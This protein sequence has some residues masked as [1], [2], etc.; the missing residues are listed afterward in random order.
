M[1]YIDEYNLKMKHAQNAIRFTLTFPVH[2][3]HQQT[4]WEEEKNKKKKKPHA[5]LQNNRYYH[6]LDST[7]TV[8]RSTTKMKVEKNM[9]R[10]IEMNGMDW[11]ESQPKSMDTFYYTQTNR[12]TNIHQVFTNQ[13][14]MRKSKFTLFTISLNIFTTKHFFFFFLLRSVLFVFPNCIH[15]KTDNPDITCQKIYILTSTQCLYLRLIHYCR[16]A[17]QKWLLSAYPLMAMS[18]TQMTVL[19]CELLVWLHHHRHQCTITTCDSE[20]YFYSSSEPF[21]LLLFKFT[22]LVSHFCTT[23]SLTKMNSISF[24]IQIFY[25]LFLQQLFSFHFI[26][27][28][29][30]RQSAQFTN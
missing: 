2:N 17:K 27:W 23:I 12:Q 20:L 4:I 29:S 1:L 15:S 25:L 19:Y 21:S 16:R 30:C 10:L 6:I 28:N 8:R 13:W 5:Q 9:N 26:N 11:V 22:S 18:T 14:T 7:T 3:R 24:R